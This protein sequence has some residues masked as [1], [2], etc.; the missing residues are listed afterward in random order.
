[1]TDAL[2]AK[3]LVNDTYAQSLMGEEGLA[4][5]EAFKA[6]ANPNG[7][8]IARCFIID[9]WIKDELAVN[10]KTTIILIGAGLDSRAF[11][12]TG[13]NWIELDEPGIIEYKNEKLPQAGCK[14]SLK[15]IPIDFETE[16]L[17][18]KLLPFRTNDKVVIVVEGVLMYLANDQRRQLLETLTASFK[19]QILLCDLMD[20]PFFDRLGSKG[21]YTELK[22][23][24]ALFRDMMDDPKQLMLSAGYKLDASK[25]NIITA[26][27]HGL[28]TIPR[29][30]VKFLMKKLMMG[31]SSYRF[32]F[33]N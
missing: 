10:Q 16:K 2:S 3:P 19:N 30:I 23:S 26:S 32:S 22:K 27:D 6:H 15:R 13:G 31:Y 25:S 11:R 17:L 14:N 7:S 12:M 9:N 28:L 21:I 33:S 8:N 5:W 1:M 18:D 20:K 4:Y 24:N 29:F